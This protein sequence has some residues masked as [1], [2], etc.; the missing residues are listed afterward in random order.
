[1]RAIVFDLSLA[2]YALA[3]AL[4]RQIPSLYWGPLSCVS[5]R[6]VPEPPL[7]GP[8]WAKVSVEAS[9]FCGSDLATVLLKMSPALSPFS[10][11]PAV[12]GHEIFGRLSEVGGDARAAGFKEGDRVVVNPAFGCRVRGLAPPCASC[13]SGHPAT[14]HHAGESAGGLA[15]G[16]TIGYHRDL[17]GG[18][19]DVVAAHTTQLHRVPDSVPDT[20]AVLT[21]PISIGLHGVLHRPPRD[22]EEVL[23]IGGG[24]IAYSVLAALRLSGRR[25]RV[26]QLVLVPFQADL[27]RALGADEVIVA[28]KED[29]MDRVVALTGARRHKPILGRDVLTGGYAVTF[30]CVGTPDSL[31]DALSYTRSQGTIVMVGACGIVPKIDLT[32]IWARELAIQGTYYYA[33]E[34]DG[35][36]TIDIATELLAGD[37]ARAVDALVTHSFPLEKYEDAIIANIDRGKSKAMKTI[38]KPAVRA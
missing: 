26:T 15:P 2:R 25:C 38:F 7:R 27:A 23:I 6:E 10:S 20:R 8:A 12:L 31:R 29:T 30:D 13:A 3:K 14:C 4:G 11:F 28:S 24:M 9:G 36:H 21:E 34:A 22:D 32:N 37:S 1:M 19:S 33:P 35:R 18:F 17:P 16:F 5:L